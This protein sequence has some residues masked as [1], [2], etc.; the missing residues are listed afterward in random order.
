M[1]AKSIYYWQGGAEVGLWK[2]CSV[3]VWPEYNSAETILE[4]LARSGYV[5]RQGN[6]PSGAPTR[7]QLIAA[8]EG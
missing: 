5:T 8:L 1:A 4:R 7:T 6:K 3:N 2:S